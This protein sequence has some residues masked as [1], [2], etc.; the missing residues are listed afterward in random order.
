VSDAWNPDQYERFKDERTRPFHD[1]L[2]MV[3]P[4]AGGRVVDLGCGTGELTNEVH[5]ALQA[6]STVGIDRSGA[7]LARAEP[8]EGVR[9]EQGDI[10]AFNGA[11]GYD[12]IFANASLQ[13]VP[14]HERLLRSLT[15][16]LRPGGQLAVQVPANADHPSHLVAAAV[17]LEPPFFDAF[18]GGPPPDPVQRNVLAPERYAEL[19]DG[20]GF[21][22]QRVLLEVYGHPMA[23]SGDV[24]EW[25]KGTTLTRF[26]ERLPG[27][28]YDA[29][30]R[31]Y[32]DALLEV[33]GDR[34][35][36]FYPFRRILF[37]A[38]RG[39]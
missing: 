33:I 2:A 31:R 28:L 7:M 34:R 4:C 18:D 3:R 32:R 6:A 13:W 14:D 25:V 21:D 23:W 16:S 19:L 1:L 12:V 10:A 36:Y 26:R 37:W 8:I 39:R 22:A 20:L 35:P 5:T 29:F 27:D 15:A 24:V 38:I 30:V 11:D 17:A 9:F